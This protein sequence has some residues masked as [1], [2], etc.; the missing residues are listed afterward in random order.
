[1]KGIIALIH[2]DCKK[3]TAMIPQDDGCRMQLVKLLAT[4]EQAYT[5]IY[6]RIIARFFSRL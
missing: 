6:Q 3:R 2:K 1:M 4:L 5:D